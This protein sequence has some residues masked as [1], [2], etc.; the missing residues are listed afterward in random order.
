MFNNGNCYLIQ[1]WEQN[2]VSHSNIQVPLYEKYLVFKSCQ[3]KI[4]NLLFYW[5]PFCI[6]K[7][8]CQ[9]HLRDI[10]S[11]FYLMLFVADFHRLLFGNQQQLDINRQDETTLRSSPPVAFSGKGVLKTCSKLTGEHSCRSSILTKLQTSKGVSSGKKT[12]LGHFLKVS[13]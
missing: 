10:C 12:N 1:F 5:I 7:C 6:W 4:W 11:S 9:T 3:S 13:R 2:E 8:Y